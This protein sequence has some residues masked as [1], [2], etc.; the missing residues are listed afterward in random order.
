MSPVFPYFSTVYPNIPL[1]NNQI[2]CYSRLW[3]VVFRQSEYIFHI[4]VSNNLTV[5]NGTDT[6][7]THI[8]S[9]IGYPYY[10]VFNS[11]YSLYIR[12]FQAL[13]SKKGNQIKS[14]YYIQPSDIWSVRNCQQGNS[15]SPTSM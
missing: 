15:A 13:G 14:I 1:Q 12:P 2:I 8:A 11:G 3:T 4:P 7:D 10:V 9:V 5:E 6:F